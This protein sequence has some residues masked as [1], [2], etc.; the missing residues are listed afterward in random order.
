L[1][2]VSVEDL[3]DPE[4]EAYELLENQRGGAVGAAG[5]TQDH[6][7]QEQSLMQLQSIR[8]FVRVLRI[9][10]EKEAGGTWLEGR[11]EAGQR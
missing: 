3:K 11:E 8:W 6:Y 5:I 2:V 7:P 10:R 1:V 9:G 4:V